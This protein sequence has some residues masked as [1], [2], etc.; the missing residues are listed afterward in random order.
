M[1]NAEPLDVK[2][3][4]RSAVATHSALSS[5]LLLTYLTGILDWNKRVGLVSRRSPLT[6]IDR[7]VDQSA[8]LWEMVTE[9]R[10]PVERAIDI[11]TGAGFPGLIWK[12]MSPQTEVVL[13]DRRA[14]KI[15]FLRRMVTVL[16]LSGVE[17]YE[18]EA[19]VV[20]GRPDLRGS[21]DVAA[22]MAV[23]GLDFTAPLVRPFLRP[24]GLFATV[25][26]IANTDETDINSCRIINY[27]N[28][29]LGQL[30]IFRFDE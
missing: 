3:L 26:S 2:Q 23:G 1:D 4:I 21:C 11:G 19:S 20:A 5:D 24:D 10:G 27:E 13:V 28:T 17:I 29:P 18:G 16:G 6:V 25:R 15:T 30:A 12:I 14:H 9:G 7:L 8:R 22:T